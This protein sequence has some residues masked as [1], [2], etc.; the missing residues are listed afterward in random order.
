M[1]KDRDKTSLLVK[2][3]VKP[4]GLLTEPLKDQEYLNVLWDKGRNNCP[5]NNNLCL[6]KWIEMPGQFQHFEGDDLFSN[7]FVR[8]PMDRLVSAWKDKIHTDGVEK[9]GEKQ[10]YFDKYTKSIL[11][12][13][14]PGKVIPTK[15]TEAFNQGN[16]FLLTTRAELNVYS[17]AKSRKSVYPGY[18]RQ[19]ITKYS[20]H[21]K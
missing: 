2:T 19:S 14:N 9:N 12:R 5:Q 21:S 6:K 15:V 16:R 10:F 13:H 11:R 8:E 7:M 20:G 4:K 18:S 3:S 1:L 17:R